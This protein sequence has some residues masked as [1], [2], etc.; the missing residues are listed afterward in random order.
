MSVQQA[1]HALERGDALGALNLV[2]RD[3]SALGLLLRG[4]AYAQLGDLE[5]AATSLES[6]ASQGDV[7]VAARARAAMVE[8]LLQ[9]A[10]PV[11]AGRA[12]LAAA[13]ELQALGDVQNLA[14]MQL[15]IARTELLLGRLAEA[16]FAVDAL[17]ELPVELKALAW[18]ARAEIA[19]RC[20]AA[21]EAKQA[22]VQASRA[23][24]CHPHALLAREL[25]TL[26]RDLEM[27]IAR[28]ARAGVARDADLAS[29]EQ[30][31]RGDVLLVDAC[32]LQ[33]VA[34]RATIPL[35]RRPVLFALL[36]VLARAW[37][38]AVPRDDLARRAF[39]VVRVNA[40]HRARLRV[41]IGRLRSAIA[42]LGTSPEATP[43]GYALRSKREV[44]SLFPRSEDEGAR[45]TLLLGDGAAWSAQS[46]AEHAGV[47]RRTA[48]RALA[49][50]LERGQVLRVGGGRDTRYLREGTP[51]A[52]RLLLLGLLPKPYNG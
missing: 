30:V 12:A 40:S 42:D 3:A 21:A 4:V 41:E 23:L 37:P 50:L 38:H 39:D 45:L 18:L 52:S 47:S 51:L 25:E 28:V 13:A 9:T 48:Q 22:L 24:E 1:A 17:A 27:P 26:T 20:T 7:V 32:R 31:S 34:G 11:V 8:V 49:A 43:E 33:V 44:I 2:G 16:R 15:T 46:L 35:A 19:I 29:I 5:L 6:A 14:L 36:D 10:G